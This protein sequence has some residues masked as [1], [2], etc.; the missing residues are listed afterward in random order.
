[1]MYMKRKLILSLLMICSLFIV[2]TSAVLAADETITIPDD[3]DDVLTYDELGEELIVDDK[4]N[5]DIVAVKYEKQ[6]SLITLTLTVK[7]SIEN[8]GDLDD[9]ENFENYEYLYYF[10]ELVTSG[11]V[12]YQ[13]IYMNTQCVLTYSS[14]ES[15]EDFEMVNLTEDNFSVDGSNLIMTFPLVD[16]NEVYASLQAVATYEKGDLDSYEYY[17]DVVLSEIEDG[18]NGNDTGDNGSNG[19]EPPTN[20]DSNQKDTSNTN[21]FLFAGIIIAVVVIGVA[22]LVYIIRR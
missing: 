3:E 8:K 13:L 7:G 18:N 9:L 1:M 16:D 6:D 12:L 2:S 11:D 22:V 5:I 15:E 4:P 21:L 19:T 10:V 20:G 17:E 14:S